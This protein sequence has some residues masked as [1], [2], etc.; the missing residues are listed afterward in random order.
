MRY[1]IIF[2]WLGSCVMQD[3]EINPTMERDQTI[4]AKSKDVVE[5]KSVIPD[6]Q[7]LR[8]QIRPGGQLRCKF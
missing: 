8:E 4:S 1:L 7:E 3:C 2:I 6:I 5:N